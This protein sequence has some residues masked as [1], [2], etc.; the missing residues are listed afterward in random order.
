MF[1]DGK[2]ET[3][4]LSKEVSKAWKERE[5]ELELARDPWPYLPYINDPDTPW[6]G[7]CNFHWTIVWSNNER[8]IQGSAD[9]LTMYIYIRFQQE[10]LNHRRNASSPVTRF[11][12]ALVRMLRW[13]GKFSRL[14]FDVMGKGPLRFLDLV[15]SS[16]NR[17]GRCNFK[18]DKFGMVPY[19]VHYWISFSSSG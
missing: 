3:E 14:N 4:I 13:K 7:S 6:L 2:R 9:F 12:G 5:R 15:I 19:G 1:L 17:G 18:H 11:V 10:S 16:E 8:H